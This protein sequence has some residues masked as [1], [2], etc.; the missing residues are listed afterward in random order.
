MGLSFTNIMNKIYSLISFKVITVILIF[1][2]LT[3]SCFMAPYLSC[4]IYSNYNGGDSMENL[5]YS[6]ITDYVENSLK[7]IPIPALSISITN[8]DKTIYS[9]SYGK[10]INNNSS[11]ALGS[12]SKAITATSVLMLLE[13]Y[14]IN[15][16]T[17]IS[18]YLTW[19]DTPFDISILD[20]LNHTSGISTYE[21]IDNLKYS[22]KYG[23]FE[24]SN[25]NYNLLGKI[26]ESISGKTFSE[27]VN[28][29]IFSKLNMVNSFSYSKNTSHNIISGYISLFGLLIP[30]KEKIPNDISWIQA[31]SG[32][33]CSSTS[34]I[35]KYLRF[36]LYY[37]Y[38]NQSLPKLIKAKGIEVCD[39][40]AIEG[41]YDN[42]GI[43]G[44]GWI[45]KN[46]NKTDIFYHTG[47]LSSYNSLSVIIPKKNFGI[48]VMCNTGD[49][50]VGTKLIEQLYE[51]IISIVI[52][53]ETAYIPV[54]SY[55]KQHSIINLTLLLLFL[56]CSLPTILFFISKEAFYPN[57]INILTF[58]VLHI[59]LPI[60]LLSIFT[61]FK[62]PFN[63]AADFA[64]D[65]IIVLT[66]C[67][68]VLI[69]TGLLKLLSYWI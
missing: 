50:F 42:K 46:V 32:Y 54:N 59:A 38:G 18:R 19:I 60:A 65:I 21:T 68:I 26:I 51:G 12:T 40:P 45:Y 25:A 8:R 15:I 1:M 33:L 63:I 7:I 49:F 37:S 27:Y 28:T 55:I 30:C 41:I 39:N 24:Y 66:Y 16:N 69:I 20:L 53:N 62:I 3:L 57:A 34:D 17:P 5:E 64:P 47:K 2:T 29:N 44:M 23:S 35:N 13:R 43:Y 67:S 22:G 10:E 11:F 4:H 14:S 61:I 56:L 48:S 31:P 9:M 58:I 6:E 36:L 52:D